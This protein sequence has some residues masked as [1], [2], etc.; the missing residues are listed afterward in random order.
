M[1]EKDCVDALRT[2]AE[3]GEPAPNLKGRDPD[4]HQ[5]RRAA[6]AHHIGVA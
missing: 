1:G 4:I 6:G 3:S 2:E 5:Q